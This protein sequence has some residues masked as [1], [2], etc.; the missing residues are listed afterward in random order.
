MPSCN[1]ASLFYTDK[2][3]QR[4]PSPSQASRVTDEEG[5]VWQCS[6]VSRLARTVC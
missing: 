2:Y 3:K 1:E 5:G 6:T 4:A